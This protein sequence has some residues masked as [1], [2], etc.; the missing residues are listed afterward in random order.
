MECAA[1]GDLAGHLEK[2]GRLQQAEAAK[3]LVQVS[4][5]VGK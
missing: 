3:Y 1:H 5:S 2:K 4:Q